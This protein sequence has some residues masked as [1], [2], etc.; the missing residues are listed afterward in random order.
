MKQRITDELQS[1]K[2]FGLIVLFIGGLFFIIH[3]MFYVPVF[4]L[5]FFGAMGIFMAV[6]AGILF[7]AMIALVLFGIVEHILKEVD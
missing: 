6:S 3:F 5:L 7:V 4:A 2:E 1:L